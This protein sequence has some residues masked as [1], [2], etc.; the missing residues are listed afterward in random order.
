MNCSEAA[1]KNKTIEMISLLGCG[2]IK[3]DTFSTA[4][5]K[6]II[7]RTQIMNL[8]NAPKNL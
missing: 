1:L 4:R 8:A 2:I 3:K 7:S 6:L 5:A